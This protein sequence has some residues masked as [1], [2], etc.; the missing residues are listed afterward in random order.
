MDYSDLF[1]GSVLQLSGLTTKDVA[2][3][4]HL[5]HLLNEAVKMR[6]GALHNEGVNFPP[7]VEKA[8]DDR[9][10]LGAALFLAQKMKP[11]KS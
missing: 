6:R 4:I 8:E 11:R 9:I 3:S 7:E 5:A 1:P 2:P 10:F